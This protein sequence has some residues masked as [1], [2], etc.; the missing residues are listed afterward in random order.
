MSNNVISTSSQHYSFS[1]QQQ[2][3]LLRSHYNNSLGY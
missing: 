2:S 3:R 1:E